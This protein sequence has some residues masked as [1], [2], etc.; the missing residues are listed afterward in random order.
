MNGSVGRM[1]ATWRYEFHACWE[2]GDNIADTNRWINA[3]AVSA[4]NC[5]SR[6]N[7][8]RPHQALAGLIPRQYLESLDAKAPPKHTLASHI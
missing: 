8:F 1:Q 7:I 2:S 3:F 6:F 5:G 4:G